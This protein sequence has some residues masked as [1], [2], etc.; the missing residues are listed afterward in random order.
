MEL[1]PRGEISDLVNTNC[2]LVSLVKISVLGLLLTVAAMNKLRLV[3]AMRCG[4]YS[5]MVHLRHSINA[6]WVLVYF[7]FLVTAVLTTVMNPPL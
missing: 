6:E 3:P 4:N 1:N 5:A 7:F 2:D